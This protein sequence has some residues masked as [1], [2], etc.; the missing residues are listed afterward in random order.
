VVYHGHRALAVVSGVEVGR[1]IPRAPPCLRR[2]G[3]CLA[4]T[5]DTALRTLVQWTVAQSLQQCRRP[6]DALESPLDFTSSN[7]YLIACEAVEEAVR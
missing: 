2:I 3:S 7:V 4:N 1:F 6:R 5:V